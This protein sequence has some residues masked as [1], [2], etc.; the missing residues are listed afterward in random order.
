[1]KLI[2]AV[3]KTGLS[4]SDTDTYAPARSP[5][6]ADPSGETCWGLAGLHSFVSHEC[7]D[8]FFQLCVLI[9]PGSWVSLLSKTYSSHVFLP[10]E[11]VPF[12]SEES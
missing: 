6:S 7:L 10:G 11:A 2:T 1:M 8:F 12:S 9:T 3:W 4:S 5:L